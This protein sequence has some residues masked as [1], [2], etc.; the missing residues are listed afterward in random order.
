M[1]NDLATLRAGIF[2]AVDI[3]FAEQRQEKRLRYHLRKHGLALRKFHSGYA[4]VCPLT[5]MAEGTGLSL[6]QVEAWLTERNAA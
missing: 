1:N 6:D 3:V 5:T 4:I 2:A